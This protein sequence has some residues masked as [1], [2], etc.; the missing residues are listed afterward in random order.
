LSLLG[1]ICV[2]R[3]GADEEQQGEEESSVPH[4]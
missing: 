1:R 3:S 4:L 2:Q